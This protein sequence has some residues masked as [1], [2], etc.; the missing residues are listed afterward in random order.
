[1][2]KSE[3]D[4]N[5]DE[6]FEQNQGDEFIEFVEFAP[7]DFDSIRGSLPAA[8]S[9]VQNL[10]TVILKNVICAVCQN[11]ISL[12]EEAK[13]LPCTHHYHGECILPWLE[14]RNT[15]PVCRFELPTDDPDYEHWRRQRGT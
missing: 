5:R 4:D 14:I 1:M 11:E 9:I 15:C 2:G 6:F 7:F 10:P 3:G 8:K 13:C 12:E